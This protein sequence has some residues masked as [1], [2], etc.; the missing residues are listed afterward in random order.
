MPVRISKE[1]LYLR[2]DFTTED[3]LQMCEE[4]AQ[5]YNRNQQ[6]DDEETVMKAQIK[7]KRANVDA[8][9]GSLSRKLNDRFEMRNVDCELVY[10][11]P[12]VGEV[13]YKRKDNGEIAKTRPM[14][15]ME[16]Q[17]DLPLQE[18]ATPEAEKESIEAS[19]KAADDFFG[20]KAVTEQPGEAAEKTDPPASNVTEMPQ[21][22]KKK[23][24]K[25]VV[26]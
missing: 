14:T 17:M 16:R 25:P 15:E 2:Y 13:S 22:G 26:N 11:F 19:A 10:D 21:G 3:R 1:S 6:I 18:P 24:G 20:E 7:D 8:T 5:A 23:N 4:L 12:N 9:V